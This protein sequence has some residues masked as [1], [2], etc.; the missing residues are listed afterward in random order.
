[1]KNQAQVRE[2]R[3]RLAQVMQRDWNARA[4]KDAFFY[5]ASW[6]RDWDPESFFSSGEQDYEKLVE[7]ILRQTGYPTAG[8]TMLEVGCGAGRMTRSFAQRFARVL[9]FDAASEMLKRGREYL[10]D[11]PNIRWI[12]GDGATLEGVEGGACDFVFSYLVLQHL[13]TPEYV[14]GM[15]REMMRVLKPGGLF[16]FQFNGASLPTMNWKGRAAWGFVDALWAIGLERGS[17]GAA[18]LL[19]LDPAMAGKSWRGAAVEAAAVRVTLQ[20]AGA[21]ETH[22]MGEST[23]MAWCWGKKIS[24]SKP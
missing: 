14:L 4:R 15:I 24:G 16:L 11:V 5:I 2:E 19:R 8:K 3:A 23:P 21:S 1:M 10:A 7:P 6:Q 17:R 20:V 12:Q 18:S 13:P 9:A 22:V